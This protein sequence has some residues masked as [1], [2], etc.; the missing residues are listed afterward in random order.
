MSKIGDLIADHNDRFVEWFEESLLVRNYVEGGSDAYGDSEQ[1]LHPDSPIET[2]GQIDQPSDP[3]VTSRSTGQETA[4]DAVVFL[5]D[6]VL[7][8]DG[9]GTDDTGTALPWPSEIEAPD[10]TI[11]TVTNV[12]DEGTGWLRCHVLN[13]EEGE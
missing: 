3:I 7:V 12:F 1:Q 9:G 4:I 11:Y 10:G 13:T 2:T 8:T 5:P 6:D